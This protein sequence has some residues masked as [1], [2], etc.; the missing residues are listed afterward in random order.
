MADYSAAK[1][2]VFEDKRHKK[3]IFEARQAL[4]EAASHVVDPQ[5]SKQLRWARE[6]MVSL[7][8]RREDYTLVAVIT[9]FDPGDG[10]WGTFTALASW[11]GHGGCDVGPPVLLRN[12][13]T[14]VEAKHVHAVVVSSSSFKLWRPSYPP[15]CLK[16]PPGFELFDEPG[17][18]KEEKMTPEKAVE[19]L[20][21][22][23]DAE[24]AF[25]EE[26]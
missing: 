14:A 1:V 21:A 15:E 5:L 13:G 18:E 23:E 2:D 25:E 26:R 24:A 9:R 17:F 12:S 3:A 19:L 4:A 8:A 20:A 16:M 6:H 11:N 10:K 22:M 7:C